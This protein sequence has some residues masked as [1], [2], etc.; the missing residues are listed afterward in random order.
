MKSRDWFTEFPLRMPALFKCKFVLTLP[1]AALQRG[2]DFVEGK[3]S[4][5][6][7]MLYS[8]YKMVNLIMR[9]FLTPISLQLVIQFLT[10]GI[11]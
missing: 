4:Q 1:D 7:W 5:F 9:A 3:R 10:T 11:S 2:I 6:I 8:L